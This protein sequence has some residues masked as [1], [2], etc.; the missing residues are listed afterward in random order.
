MAEASTITGSRADM[1]DALK[2]GFG[3]I[4]Q[5]LLEARGNGKE[6]DVPVCCKHILAVVLAE[7]GGDLFVAGSAGGAGAEGGGHA[8]TGT[9]R[10]SREKGGR[11]MVCCTVGSLEEFAAVAAGAGVP[12]VG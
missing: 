6:G 3:G 5:A 12:V 1:P 4:P 2:Y 10:A 8:D 7:C 11:G 9:S